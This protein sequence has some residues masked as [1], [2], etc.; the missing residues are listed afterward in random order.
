MK[1]FIW[2][3]G[4]NGQVLRNYVDNHSQYVF[5]GFIDSFRTGMKIYKPE[6]LKSHN[7]DLVI[8]SNS[9]TKQQYDINN[10]LDMLN[11]PKDKAIF[12]FQENNLMI[13]V[14]SSYN[15]Y[16]EE[17][18]KRVCWLREYAAFVKDFNIQGNVA[19]C[20]VNR[21]EFAEYINKYFSNK[22]LYLFDTFLGFSSEDLAV[23]KSL[24]NEEFI[25]GQFNSHSIFKSTSVDIV[26]KRMPYFD[27][28]EFHQGWFPESAKNIDDLF[29]FVNLDMD[30]YQPMLAG[31]SFFYY[32]MVDGGVILLHDYFNKELPGVKQ[33]VAC[34][35]HELLKHRLRKIPIADGLSL[36]IVK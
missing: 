31:L 2:G 27:L 12:L 4:I 24:N 28:C 11:V 34:F 13:E 22:K 17:T 30:L 3:A 16:N 23:E 1:V 29:C 32:K 5:G 25:R 35:E 9:D 6:Y 20:G 18:D 19:E 8:V 33:A 14:F 15:K 21:G 10:Q 7:Y 26:K 36:A